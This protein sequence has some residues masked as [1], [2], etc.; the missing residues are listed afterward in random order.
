MKLFVILSLILNSISILARFAKLEAAAW[1]GLVNSEVQV[2]SS[3]K[4]KNRMRIVYTILKEEGKSL[5][6]YSWTYNPASQNVK[7][8]SAKTETG[9]IFYPVEKNQIEDKPVASSSLSGFDDTNQIVINFPMVEIG[10]KLHLE[11]E[12]L[13][14]KPMIEGLWSSVSALWENYPLLKGSSLKI[15]SELPIFYKFNSFGTGVEKK[16]KIKEEKYPK[17]SRYEVSFVTKE[18]LFYCVVEE[19]A[20]YLSG[21]VPYIIFSNRQSYEG[22]FKP[23][24]EEYAKRL[25]YSK[26]PKLIKELVKGVS[27]KNGF[28]PTV[29]LLMKK[30]IESVRYSGDWRTVEGAIFPRSFEEIKKTQYGDCKDFS[31]LL[32][33]VLKEL[34][35]EA[36]PALVYR[37]AYGLPLFYDFPMESSFNHAIVYVKEKG[38]SFFFDPTNSHSYVDSPLYDISGRKALV[39][40]P[41]KVFLEE[42]PENAPEKSKKV[43]QIDVT[44]GE[45]SL[46]WLAHVK[47]SFYKVSALSAAFNLK[48]R[49]E[50]QAKHYF[51]NETIGSAQVKEMLEYDFPR[52][53]L[54]TNDGPEFFQSKFKAIYQPKTLKTT[55]GRALSLEP[56]LPFYSTFN[57]ETYVGGLQ[58]PATSIYRLETRFKDRQIVPKGLQRRSKNELPHG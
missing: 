53:L 52:E 45:G 1:N 11:V 39:L 35:Y 2:F 41:K 18:D 58:L 56:F 27:K 44:V 16:V 49:S 40:D 25:S 42:I 21:T 48:G 24:A 5:G 50:E 4:A 54:V 19:T 22:I 32:V 6:T 23:V 34:G 51:A 55:S 28:L 26:S 33:A 8:L 43:I 30:I 9:G 14:E 31:I 36:H 37:G 3:G 29:K 17:K 20:A 7:I 10:S 46:P 15:S 57:A 13:T 12:E 38:K 47:E